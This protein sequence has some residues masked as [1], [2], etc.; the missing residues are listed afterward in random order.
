MEL[1]ARGEPTNQEVEGLRTTWKSPTRHVKKWF[2]KQYT[3]D[4]LIFFFRISIAISWH[5]ERYLGKRHFK[6]KY[7]A[8]LKPDC[9]ET[10]EMKEGKS[11]AIDNGW[12]IG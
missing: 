3:I 7:K 12:A 9:H 10:I 5:L 8:F 1:E 4:V 11:L 6:A 2:L